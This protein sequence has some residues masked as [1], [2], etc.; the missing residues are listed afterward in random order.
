I[1]P[2]ARGARAVGSM[3]A[4]VALGAG[5]Y[6]VAPLLLLDGSRGFANLLPFVLAS[7]SLAMLFGLAARTGPPVPHY[8]TIGPLLVAPLVGVCLLTASPG[9]LWAMVALNGF[10]CLAAWV[11]H[12]YALAHGTEEP[13]P[14]PEEAAQTDQERIVKLGQH[15]TKKL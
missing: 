12:R 15:L 6:F 5:S 14:S 7:V 10:L 1:V 11:R 4:L 3:F 2:G 9:L 13:E 8:F